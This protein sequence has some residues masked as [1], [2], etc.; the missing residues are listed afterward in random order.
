MT[1]RYYQTRLTDKKIAGTHAKNL[2]VIFKAKSYYFKKN[3][4][5]PAMCQ[6]MEGAQR[7]VMNSLPSGTLKEETDK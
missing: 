7:A 1:D 5:I 6:K 3:D 4:H 2:K